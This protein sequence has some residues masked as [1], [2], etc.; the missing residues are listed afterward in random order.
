MILHGGR[1][2]PFVRRVELWLAAQQRPVERRYVSVFDP[3]FGGMLDKNPL[4]RVP[5]L[6]LADG[7]CLFETSAIIDYLED[8][9]APE[10]RLIPA[11]GPARW[12][13]LQSLSLAHGV[14]EKTVA[15]VYERY[16]RPLDKQWPDWR[17]RI[18]TQ[19]SN[20]LAALDS[21]VGVDTAPLDG[22][23]IAA[24]C[25]LDLVASRFPALADPALIHLRRLSDAANAQPVFAATYPPDPA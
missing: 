23:G 14:A 19:I 1:V 20:G 6:E 11:S 13:A 18:K 15:L 7:T 24:V 22:L 10:R 17:N 5:V 4:G 3:D 8:T 25:A 12:Q 2:S 16:Q 21:V 9:A